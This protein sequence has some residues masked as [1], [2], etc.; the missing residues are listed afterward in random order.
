MRDPG[1]S[2]QVRSLKRQKKKKK[3]N[4]KPKSYSPSHMECPPPFS[5]IAQILF[6][7]K[8]THCPLPSLPEFPLQNLTCAAPSSTHHTSQNLT[9]WFP[10]PQ[11]PA[12]SPTMYTGSEPSGCHPEQLRAV[13]KPAFSK[14]EPAD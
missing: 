12:E 4:L 14:H 5:P 11:S 7:F 1:D 3:V 13:A 9:Q 2:Y 10:L 6:I 8:V